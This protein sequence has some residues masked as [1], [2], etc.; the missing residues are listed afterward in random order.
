MNI[1]YLKN[2]EGKILQPV[3]SDVL[4]YEKFARGKKLRIAKIPFVKLAD[5]MIQQAEALVINPMGFNLILK[6]RTA[7]KDHRIKCMICFQKEAAV[8]LPVFH[9]VENL[10]FRATI[11]VF[12]EILRDAAM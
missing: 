5:I 4:E 1:P 10:T 12:H 6:Q 11:T 3:F 2:K 8:R 7:K 9:T